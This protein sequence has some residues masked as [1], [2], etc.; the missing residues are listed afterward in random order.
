MFVKL[1]ITFPSIDREKL[2]FLA[3][4]KACPLALLLETLSDPAKS[5]KFNTPL[6]SESL[7]NF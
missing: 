5:T 7:G 1:L 2:I 6:F 4:S 3:S